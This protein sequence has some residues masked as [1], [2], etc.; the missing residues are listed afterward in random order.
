[1]LKS[2]A[3]NIFSTMNFYFPADKYRKGTVSRQ[4]VSG[5]EYK[6]YP[7]YTIDVEGYY[8]NFYNNV[9]PKPQTKYYENLKGLFYEGNGKAYGFDFYLKKDIGRL[10]G[11]IGYTLSRSLRTFPEINSSKE[12]YSDQHRLHNFTIALQYR[13]PKKFYFV[14]DWRWAG[15]LPYTAALGRAGTLYSDNPFEPNEHGIIYRYRTFSAKNIYRLPP[16]HRLDIGFTKEF[17]FHNYSLKLSINIFNLYNRLNTVKMDE[18][19]D[20]DHKK[21][22]T[23]L[24]IIPSFSM[25]VRF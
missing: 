4:F 21:Y 1:M 12:F 10:T 9:L 14:L 15:G 23:L 24:P 22:F 25:D 3:F 7:G 16:Y 11:W 6:P 2:E 17:I 13:F 18:F 20:E 19:P 8:S 5:F